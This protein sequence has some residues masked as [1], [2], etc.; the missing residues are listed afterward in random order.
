MEK[1]EILSDENSNEAILNSNIVR[2]LEVPSQLGLLLIL[3]SPK[4]NA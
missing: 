3:I 2:Q 1:E 4:N